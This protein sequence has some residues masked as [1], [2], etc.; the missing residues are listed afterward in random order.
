MFIFAYLSL[1]LVCNFLEDWSVYYLSLRFYTVINANTIPCHI[2]STNTCVVNKRMNTWMNISGTYSMGMAFHQRCLKHRWIINFNFQKTHQPLKHNG[3]DICLPI[4]NNFEQFHFY[5]L[6]QGRI[7][8]S[9]SC[10]FV[11]P[12]EKFLQLWSPTY[13]LI[14]LIDYTNLSYLFTFCV[15]VLFFFF[16]VSR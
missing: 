3:R 8:R 14:I 15:L 5:E 2:V 9:F 6:F 16:S 7:F 10:F 11:L 4:F 1:Y 12:S 13:W